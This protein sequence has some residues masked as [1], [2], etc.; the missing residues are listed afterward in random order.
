[1]AANIK[2]KLKPENEARIVST[3]PRTVTEVPRG[4]FD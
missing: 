2:P 1:M 4:N 3:W